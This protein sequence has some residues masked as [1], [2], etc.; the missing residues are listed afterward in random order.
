MITI[1]NEQPADYRKVEEIIRQSFWNLYI[2]GANEHYLVHKLR[3]H[4]DYIPELSFVI[5]K[6]EDIIGSIHFTHAHIIT[7]HGDNIPLIH[8]GPVCIIPELQRKGFWTRINYLCYRVREKS[9]I[10]CY[11]A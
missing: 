10:S 6:D 7:P 4:K 3:S 1:R 8:F 9:R 11:S 5:E 2:P